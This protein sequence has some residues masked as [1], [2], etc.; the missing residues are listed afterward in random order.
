MTRELVISLVDDCNSQDGKFANRRIDG[1]L[2][3]NRG[4]KVQ[5][6]LRHWRAIEQQAIKV[7]QFAALGNNLRS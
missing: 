5:P 6:A 2:L 1:S 4:E 7:M 3:S